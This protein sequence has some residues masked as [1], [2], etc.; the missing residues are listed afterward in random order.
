MLRRDDK[1]TMKNN[2]KYIKNPIL[3]FIIMYF[4]SI[5]KGG[6]LHLS[7]ENLW[8]DMLQKY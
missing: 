3:Y 7:L 2:K 6:K 4:Q 8:Y 1:D 5:Q